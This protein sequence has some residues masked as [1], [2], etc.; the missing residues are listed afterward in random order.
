MSAGQIGFASAKLGRH[1]LNPMIRKAFAILEVIFV[2]FAAIPYLTLGIFRL[3]P[4]F[5]TWQTKAVG[6]PFPVFFHVVAVT[7]VLVLI[8]FRRKKP[9]DYGIHFHDLKYQLDIMLTCFV[10][11]AVAGVPLGMGVNYKSW[12][13]ALILAGIEVAVLL[14]LARLLRQK[15][16]ARAAGIMAAGLV[17]VPGLTPAAGS[18]AGKA[19]VLFLTYALFVGFGEEILY[20]GYIQS[21][22]NEVFGKPFKFFG[23]SFGWGAI[24]TSLL[25]GLMHVGV[26]RWILGLN[27]EVT[28]AWGFWTFF[29]GL[30]FSYVREKS[31]SI[32]PSA[33]LH[34]LPQAI[35]TVAMLFLR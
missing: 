1:D 25:F 7:A 30:V 29:S 2:A 34:G 24:A 4:R 22:L 9:A 10:P 12:G 33:L 5:E 17:L 23:V 27:Y 31:G 18:T 14:V 6:F 21:R 13:G 32:L 19:V 20:R 35:G 26:Q 16:S 8:L 28:L 15:P 11:V 3:F